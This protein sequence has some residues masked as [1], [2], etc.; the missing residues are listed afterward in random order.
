MFALLTVAAAS[1]VFTGICKRHYI[2]QDNYHS[3]SCNFSQSGKF[4]H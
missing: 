2:T 1:T 3:K 4:N